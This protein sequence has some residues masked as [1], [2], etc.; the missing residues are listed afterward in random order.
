M[1]YELSKLKLHNINKYFEQIFWTVTSDYEALKWI[2]SYSKQ[3]FFARK[4]KTKKEEDK[5]DIMY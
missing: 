1:K 2:V 3:N 5:K 4:R